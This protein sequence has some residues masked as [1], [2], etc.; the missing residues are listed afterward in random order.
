[1]WLWKA[2]TTRVW[3]SRI[4]LFTHHQCVLMT[5][6]S[7]LF[8]R[9]SKRFFQWMDSAFTPRQAAFLNQ[10]TSTVAGVLYLVGLL[11]S[12]FSAAVFAIVGMLVDFSTVYL[13]HSGQISSRFKDHMKYPDLFW[14][15]HVGF[16]EFAYLLLLIFVGLSLAG[17]T[18][19]FL[20]P[21]L[22]PVFFT[23]WLVTYVTGVYAFVRI[24]LLSDC[25]E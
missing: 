13:V 22:Y 24:E 19:F 17:W 15:L 7:D 16:V 14:T 9:Y 3:R 8:V 18:G 20:F 2:R 21:F 23:A 10:L 25:S 1:M 4:D 12:P 11:V 6:L 5:F